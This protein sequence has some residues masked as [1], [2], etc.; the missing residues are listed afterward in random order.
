MKTR[1]LNLSDFSESELTR[2]QKTHIIG[3]ILPPKTAPIDPT[4]LPG[5]PVPTTPT[6]GSSD[7]DIKDI[8]T[9]LMIVNFEP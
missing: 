7:G 2:N 8:D 5:Q 6:P 1:K 3:G 4:P 9:T